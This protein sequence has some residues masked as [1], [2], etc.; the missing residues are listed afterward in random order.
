[1]SYTVVIPRP[2]ACRAACF[3]LDLGGMGEEDV[4]P[5]L[6]DDAPQAAVVNP[7][8]DSGGLHPDEAC[9]L[10]NGDE[11][12]RVGRGQLVLGKVS[13]EARTARTR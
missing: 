3:Q 6:D 5:H 8:A 11:V 9:G 1:M 12:D 7:L 13:H 4:L 2:S 10:A